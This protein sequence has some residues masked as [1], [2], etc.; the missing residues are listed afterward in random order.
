MSEEVKTFRTKDVV[1]D[2]EDLE[3]R[4]NKARRVDP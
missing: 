1:L 2:D 4:K 3:K